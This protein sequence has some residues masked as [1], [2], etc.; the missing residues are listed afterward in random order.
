MKFDGLLDKLIAAAEAKNETPEA[1]EVRHEGHAWE[2]WTPDYPHETE[3]RYCHDCKE[4]ATWKG[5]RKLN[6]D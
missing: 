1:W 2:P 3:S 4:D 6:R 5:Q